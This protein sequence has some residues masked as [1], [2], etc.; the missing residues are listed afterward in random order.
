MPELIGTKIAILHRKEPI[1]TTAKVPVEKI[2]VNVKKKL[3]KK[4]ENAIGMKILQD[5]TVKKRNITAD[6]PIQ[7]IGES[8][9]KENTTMKIDR[10]IKTGININDTHAKSVPEIHISARNTIESPYQVMV[11]KPLA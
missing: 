2:I 1:I 7:R 10:I 9:G 4:D 11:V 3:I 5:G 6:P 8:M